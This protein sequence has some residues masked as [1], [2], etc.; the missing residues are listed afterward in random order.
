MCE[1]HQGP[2]AGALPHQRPYA[3]LQSICSSRSST[4]LAT[5]R[6]GRSVADLESPMERLQEW[7]GACPS[8]PAG[9]RKRPKSPLRK[10]G[11]LH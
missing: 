1:T 9:A 6:Q 4:A 2:G 7:R 11:T 5:S 3:R 8:L 10:S